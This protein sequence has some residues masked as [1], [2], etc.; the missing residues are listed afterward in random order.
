MGISDYHTPVLLEES[1]AG[2]SVIAGGT[3]LDLTFGGGG[4]SREILKL[5]GDGSL[6]GFDQDPDAAANKIQDKRFSLVPHN[7]RFLKNFL[8]YLGIDKVDGIVADL[9]V[10]SHHLNSPE[11]GFSF[12][13]DAEL[14]MRM[15]PGMSQTAKDIVNNYSKEELNRIFK[16]YGELERPGAFVGRIL[17]YREEAKIETT[18]ELV[19]CLNPLLKRGKENKDLARVFQAL[20]LEVNQEIEGLSSMLLQSLDVMKKGSRLVII[21]YHSLEDRLVKNFFRSGNFSGEVLK[22]LY[23]VPITP[24]NL[25]NRKLITPSEEELAR[26]PRARSAKLRIAEKNV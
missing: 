20:R 21:S 25:V 12:R 10:S 23:G 7:F 14:D 19:S 16:T 13:Y 8:D 1:I 9:G 4:H 18:G 15:N 26:N 2:L 22:D 3:Y 24:F 17:R 5:L 11:R 6:I